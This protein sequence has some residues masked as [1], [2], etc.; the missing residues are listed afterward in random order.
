M[1]R[2]ILKDF[3]ELII[4]IGSAQYSHTSTNPFTSGERRTMI[5]R[6]LEKEGIESCEIVAI[7]D[8][9]DHDTW[10]RYVRS[11]VP[12]FSVVFSN[13][14][15]TIRLFR[16]KGYDVREPPLHRREEYSGT[17]VRRRMAGGGD[18]QSLLPEVVVD[19]LREIGGVDR[20]IE[21]LRSGRG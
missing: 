15:L 4:G 13:D 3:D 7:D 11:V 6:A 20:V 10:V 12:G 1:I 8:T 2:R 14:P 9:N 21:A 5:D 17:E 18:W 16:E 19:Y